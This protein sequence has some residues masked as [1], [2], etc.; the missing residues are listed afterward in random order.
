MMNCLKYNLKTLISF[1]RATEMKYLG[2][3]IHYIVKYLG[4]ENYDIDERN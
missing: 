2:I 1:K 4:Y 3:R